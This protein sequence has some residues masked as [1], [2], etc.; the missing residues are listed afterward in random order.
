[1]KFNYFKLL[2]AD[3]SCEVTSWKADGIAYT[4]ES[5]GCKACDIANGVA[6]PQYMTDRE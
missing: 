1:M 6:A 2:A 3:L 4:I 5:A